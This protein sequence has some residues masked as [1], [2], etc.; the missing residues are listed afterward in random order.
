MRLLFVINSA[1]FFVS[2]RL[3]VALGALAAGYE[4]HVAGPSGT[5]ADTIEAYGLRYHAVNMSRSGRNLFAELRVFIELCA[6]LRRLSPDI[7][8]LI[9]IKPVLYGCLAARMFGVPSVV[10]AISGLGHVFGEALSQRILR[11]ALAPAYKLALRH[12][13]LRVIFQN[14]TDRAVLTE[15]T[16]LPAGSSLMIRGSGVDMAHY[17]VQPEPSGVPVVT[18]A[19]RLVAT[20]GVREF[21]EMARQLRAKGVRAR[22][23]LVGKP[24]PGNPLTITEEEIQSWH[25]SGEVEILGY[26]S[27]I[28]EIFCQSNLV[29]LPSYYGEGMPK[30]LL[31]AAACG[32]AVIT[33]DHPGCRDAIEPNVTGLLVPPRDVKRLAKAVQE[34][35]E[36]GEK[37][38][39][40]GQSGRRL[41]EKKFDVNAVVADHIRLYVELSNHASTGKA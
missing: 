10:V 2:H 11:A 34:L 28:Y 35:V 36:D 21:M 4:V 37:R 8:H 33:T 31:E 3:P 40:M 39:D 29:V 23:W 32:R 7:L 41:A 26:R 6:L 27:D 1:E 19:S 12:P 15:L 20:K 16:G 9:T 13:N 24:D 22:F 25:E 14:P 5:G 17:V 30:V 38:R 18:F